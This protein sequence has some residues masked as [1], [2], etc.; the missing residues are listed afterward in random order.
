MVNYF[1]NCKDLTEIKKRFRS[2]AFQ[3]HPDKNSEADAIGIMQEIN[4]QYSELLK[5]NRYDFKNFSSD[6]SFM[7]DIDMEKWNDLKE[8]LKEKFPY[9]SNFIDVFFN[10]NVINAM[11]GAFVKPRTHAKAHEEYER[12]RAEAGEEKG[13]YDNRLKD[14]MKNRRR[15]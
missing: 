1:D 14:I 11:V 5:M 10:P 6:H 9:N 3:Y 4:G 13:V 7:S 8:K 15:L 12:R 2:L